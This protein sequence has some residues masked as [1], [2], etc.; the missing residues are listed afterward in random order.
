MIIPFSLQQSMYQF[1]FSI[2]MVCLL[3]LPQVYEFC[4]YLKLEMKFIEFYLLTLYPELSLS[5]SRFLSWIRAGS[6]IECG[7][8]DHMGFKSPVGGG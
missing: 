7:R 4:K 5:L 3:Q 2:L 1:L 6:D 8:L